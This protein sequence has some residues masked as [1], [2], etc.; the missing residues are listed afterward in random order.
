M[1]ATVAIVAGGGGPLGHATAVALAADGLTVVAVD[2]T[3]HA[4]G[5]LPEDIRREV[6]DMTILATEKVTRKTL[7]EQD[8]R[9]LLEEALQEL[10]FEA[11]S[12]GAHN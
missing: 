6:A 11:L 12:Q 1:S 2:R 9:R 10:D 5:D 7:S 3:E 8:Q 4:I